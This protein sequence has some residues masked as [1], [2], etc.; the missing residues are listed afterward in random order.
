M[1]Y[2]PVPEELTLIVTNQC[3]ATCSHCISASSP[4]RRER[5][6]L[7]QMCLAI[8]ELAGD[9]QLKI[10]TFTG[11][12]PTLLGRDLLDAISHAA[13]KG[14]PTRLVTNAKWAKTEPVARGV[15]TELRDAGLAEL[16]LSTDDYHLPHIPLTRVVNAWRA[17]KG[18]GFC[19][20]VI[21]VAHAEGST[22]TP[23]YVESI[24]G[25]KVPYAYNDDGSRRP[26]PAAAADGTI[27]LIS[28]S[29][30][31][32][33]G[34]GRDHVPVESIIPRKRSALYGPCPIAHRQIAVTPKM[35]LAS[36]CGCEVEDNPVLDA[37]IIGAPGDVKKLC[38]KHDD[39]IL[40]VAIATLGPAY[41]RDVASEANP[42]LRFNDRYSNVCEICEEVTRRRDVLEVLERQLPTIA[43][44]VLTAY[45]DGKNVVVGPDADAANPQ[46]NH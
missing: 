35:H 42:A 39:N 32:V 46:V 36:C 6:S 11:G 22:V 27:Y 16:N 43:Q 14:I 8:D 44:A 3:N 45:P 17:S 10:V 19:A 26:L 25:E 23:E 13:S 33:L 15:L 18:M 7:D 34:R 21:P 4:S 30:I 12:E 5:L 2:L 40:M 20:V 37:G 9:N 28:N 24:I 29:R 38:A 1:R 41:L 31:Q